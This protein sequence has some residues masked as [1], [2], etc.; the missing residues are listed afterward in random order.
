MAAQNIG[1]RENQSFQTSEK[2]Q[3]ANTVK[4]LNNRQTVTGICSIYYITNAAFGEKCTDMNEHVFEK[5]THSS[6]VW[7]VKKTASSMVNAWYSS[8]IFLKTLNK[9]CT[10][11][12]VHRVLQ[13]WENLPAKDDIFETESMWSPDEC[14]NADVMRI[15]DVDWCNDELSSVITCRYTAAADEPKICAIKCDCTVS[16]LT[17]AYVDLPLNSHPITRHAWVKK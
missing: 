14:W 16:K 6:P 5:L 7:V 12:G 2:N 11:N 1:W 8:Q 15:W 10:A 9:I 17:A 13:N 3:R 4:N